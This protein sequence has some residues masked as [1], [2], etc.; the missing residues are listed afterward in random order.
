LLGDDLIQPLQDST[1]WVGQWFGR[2]FTGAK[3]EW[4]GGVNASADAGGASDF[5]P[6]AHA[7][8]ETI[9]WNDYA[10]RVPPLE[11]QLEVSRRRG[12]LV[13]TEKIRAALA[14]HPV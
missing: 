6:T 5:G 9:H 2:A 7:H 10:I 12:L 13:R 4:L 8:L 11:L 14:H 3:L 1:G